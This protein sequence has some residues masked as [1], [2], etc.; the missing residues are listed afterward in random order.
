MKKNFV[1]G[2]LLLFLLPKN[3]IFAQKPD[4]PPFQLGVVD[5]LQSNILGEKRVLNIYLPEGYSPDSARLYPVIYLLDGSADEDFIHIVG[6]AQ[7]CN[8][9]WIDLLPKSIVVGIANV[10]RRRDFTFPTTIEKDQKDFPTAGGSERFIAFLEKELQPFIKKNY[11]TDGKKMLIGQSLGGLLAAEI[12]FKKPELFTQ[13]V[14]VS[15]SFWWDDESLLR[16]EKQAI[17]RPVEVYVAVGKEGKVMVRGSK[18][19]H[20]LLQR[21]ASPNLRVHFDYL[22]KENHATILHHAVFR[23]FE[24]L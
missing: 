13:Y 12:L 1:L 23:A 4:L 20:R 14:I 17:T 19:L 3:Q 8:F 21:S 24:W 18:K 6:L 9:P 22:K 10:D 15:P 7:F 5:E 16:I 11:K 2:L